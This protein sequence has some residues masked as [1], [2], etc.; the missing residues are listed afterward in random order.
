V[1]GMAGIQIRGSL[2]T[3]ALEYTPIIT[4]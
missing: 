4:A 3:F 1:L 2:E